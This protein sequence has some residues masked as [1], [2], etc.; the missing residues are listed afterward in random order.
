M[1][2]AKSHH[3]FDRMGKTQPEMCRVIKRK[4]FLRAYTGVN[5]RIIRNADLH[6]IPF[7]NT[8]SSSVVV[9]VGRCEAFLQPLVAPTSHDRLP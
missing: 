4:L 6:S 5:M 8:S 9:V 3:A 1:L 7:E 2:A